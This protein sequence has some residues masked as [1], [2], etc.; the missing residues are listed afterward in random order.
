MDPVIPVFRFR[1]SPAMESDF[2]YMALGYARSNRTLFPAAEF[3]LLLKLFRIKIP[4]A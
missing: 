1:F 4:V 3:Y 2:G